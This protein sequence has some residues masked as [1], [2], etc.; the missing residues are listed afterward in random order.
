[1]E[2]EI[3]LKLKA[4]AIFDSGQTKATAIARGAGVSERTAFRYLAEF[5]EEE[6]EISK[7]SQVRRKKKRTSK[8]EA[9]VIAKA[10]DRKKIWSTRAIGASVG[11]SH[12]TVRTIIVEK[13]FKFQKYNKELRLDADNIKER[14]NFA[15]EMKGR[16]LEWG[17][18]IFTDECSFWQS[19]TKPDRL[20]TEDPFKEEGVGIHGLKLHCWGAISAM[21][22]LRLEIFE[23]NMTATKLEGIMRN[24][25]RELNELYPCGFIW[26]QDNSGVHRSNTVI[27][28]I[29]RNMPQNLEWPAYSPDLSPIENVWS[30]LKVKVAQDSPRTMRTLKLSIRKHWNSM[31]PA[32]L[33]PFINCMPNRIKRL[34]ENKGGRI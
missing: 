19:N 33:A 5:K 15:K 18:T 23:D 13:G 30:W 11:L 26:Q 12:T 32:F 25:L 4:K 7:N 16:D 31:T 34:I 3:P 22:A 6:P 10:R 14:L 24:R 17:F 9:K 29:H 28:F 8:L 2:I 27:N 21:G 1:M 20:W